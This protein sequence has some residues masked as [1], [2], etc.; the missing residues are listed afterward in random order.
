MTEPNCWHPISEAAVASLR[1]VEN[2]APVVSGLRHWEQVKLHRE[3]LRNRYGGQPIV[4][5][6]GERV[7]HVDG[8]GLQ[9]AMLLRLGLATKT[10]HLGGG[11]EK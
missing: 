7:P 6:D 1:H 9:R 5:S 11:K 8:E 2:V 4:S 3:G 10:C